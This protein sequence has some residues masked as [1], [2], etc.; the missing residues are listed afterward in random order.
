MSEIEPVPNVALERMKVGGVAL[1]I[2]VRAMRSAEIAM[3]AKATGHDFLFID[4]QHAAFNLETISQLA[5]TAIGCGVTPMVRVRAFDDP[6][7][8]RLLDAGAMGIIVPDVNTASQAASAVA[9]V[10]FP[11]FGRRSI[12]GPSP[13][14]GLRGVPAKVQMRVLNASTAV[15]CMIETREALANIEHIAAVDGVDALHVGCNDLLVDLGKPGE[16]ECAEIIAAIDLVITAARKNNIHAGLGGD[17][18]LKR[19]KAWIDRGVSFLTN[20]SDIAMLMTEAGRRVSEL[21]A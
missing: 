3:I 6:D 10:R 13:V 16:F 11:P 4:A 20:Q 12:G 2:I 7:I 14:F 1:G 19:Q 8:P 15:I 5:L 17:K 18:D 9:A 21:R